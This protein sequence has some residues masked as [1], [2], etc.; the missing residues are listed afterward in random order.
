MTEQ[1]VTITVDG[2][3][4]DVRLNRPDKINALD[5]AMFD[6]I[7]NAIDQ[8]AADTAVR[9]VVLSGNGRGFCA[10][11]DLSN[12]ANSDSLSDLMPRSHGAANRP[13]QVAWGWRTLPVPVIAAV[14]GIG[15]GGGFQIL[16]G[17]DM[18]IMTPDARLSIMEMKW[19]LVPDMA[20]IALW[21]G[22]VRDDL[23][24]ELSYTARQFTGEEA[25]GFGFATRL[26][27]DPHA[28][29]MALAQSIA[30]RNPDA[31]RAVKR[32]YNLASDG[33]DNAALLLAESREQ[34]AIMRTP[35]QMEAVMAEMQKRPAQFKDGR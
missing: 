35:N 3:V 26:S 9:V 23:L 19:G 24:R 11:L 20:G 1:R 31:V 5:T 27:A 15:F 16:S 29:A 25:A 8:L 18:R 17:A 10:G 28:D 30:G 2:G 4:A 6:G 14:H 32:L 12:F 33:A 34:Q 7:I 21:R 13:Q 22:L